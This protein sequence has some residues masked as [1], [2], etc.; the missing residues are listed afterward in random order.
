VATTG[1]K[2]LPI[3]LVVRPGTEDRLLIPVGGC[4]LDKE[5]PVPIA[6]GLRANTYISPGPNPGRDKC[7]NPM[8]DSVLVRLSLNKFN[9]ILS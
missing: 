5:L 9:F 4:N 8:R 7:Q 3:P 1:T 2:E 6:V